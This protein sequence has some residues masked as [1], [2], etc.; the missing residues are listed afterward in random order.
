MSAVTLS[1]AKADA[2]RGLGPGGVS[3]HQESVRVPF[4]TAR[5][6]GWRRDNHPAAR[7]RRALRQKGTRS[8]LAAKIDC[9]KGPFGRASASRKGGASRCS[10]W[11]TRSR[12]AFSKCLR[13]LV[14][15]FHHP[16]M[17]APWRSHMRSLGALWI[18]TVSQGSSIPLTYSRSQRQVIL[19][20][21]T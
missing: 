6:G 8:V 21:M 2:R 4:S 10:Q 11:T 3:L 9:V 12:L 16:L 19:Q 15:P 7:K 18:P 5:G 17:T 20:C 13:C 1:E 14:P